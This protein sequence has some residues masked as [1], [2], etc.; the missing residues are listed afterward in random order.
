MYITT[1]IKQ[2]INKLEIDLNKRLEELKTLGWTDQGARNYI[3]SLSETN[4][5]GV[6]IISPQYI[7]IVSLIIISII[8]III[9]L[10][11]YNSNKQKK[12]EGLIQEK[13]D[14]EHKKLKEYSNTNINL[15]SIINKIGE[16]KFQFKHIISLLKNK[17]MNVD[18]LIEH[19]LLVLFILLDIIFLSIK[20]I[21]SIYISLKVDKKTSPGSIINHK[22]NSYNERKNALMLMKNKDLKI[23]LRGIPYISKMKKSQLVDKILSLEFNKVD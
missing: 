2:W 14:S 4:D 3:D 6:L 1:T 17:A 5:S 9:I 11:K 15:E 20:I 8:I 16:S 10:I 12:D 22:L 21:I 18:L 19:F 23:I 7:T 13:T